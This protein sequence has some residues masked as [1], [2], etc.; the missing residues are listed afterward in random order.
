[1]RPGTAGASASGSRTARRW[2]VVPLAIAL[3]SRVVSVVIVVLVAPVSGGVVRGPNPFAIWDWG[4]YS[5]IARLGYHGAPI[6]KWY[7]DYAFYPGWPAVIKLLDR[8]GLPLE[9]LAV[10]AANA[11]FIVAALLAWR[12]MRQRLGEPAATWGL[13]LLV[14]APPA[15]AFSLAYAEPLFLIGAALALGAAADWRARTVGAALAAFT[16]VTG[17]AVLT[18]LAV[19]AVRTSGAERR[20]A[21]VAVLGGI[22]AFAAWWVFVAWIT[23]DPAGAM[24]GSSTWYHEPA[25]R[26]LRV[27]IAKH[28]VWVVAWGAFAMVVG[29]GTLLLARRHPDLFAYSA[30]ALVLGA[31]P[32]LVGGSMHSLPRYALVAFP[33]FGALAGRLGRRGSL[34]MLAVFLAGQVAFAW[35]A[36][37]AAGTQAP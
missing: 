7:V 12:V 18:G 16:R 13:L 3:L 19:R 31:M 33:A 10:V 21:I 27:L 15:Y 4:W 28:P 35:W 8:T 37:P 36:I 24:K 5:Q 25:G 29:V 34:V 9:V 2:F 23:G 1:M 26:V 30:T 14:F 17:L 32:I 22:V 11:L 20:T 6:S